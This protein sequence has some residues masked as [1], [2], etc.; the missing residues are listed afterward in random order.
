MTPLNKTLSR[1]SLVPHR[2]RRIVITL[3]PGDLLALR[4]E[5]RRTEFQ[6]PIAAIFDWMAKREA[7]RAID[8]RRLARKKTAQR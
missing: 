4:E 6:E 1:R 7:Q 2:G 5:R 3:Y 8:A